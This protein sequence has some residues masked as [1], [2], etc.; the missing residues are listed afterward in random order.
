M[1]RKSENIQ[2]QGTEH[3]RR[4][5]LSEE[6]KRVIK[7]IYQTGEYSQ[8]QLAAMY[9]VSRRL[10]VFCIYPE[11]LEKNYQ[12]RVA[13]GGSKIYYDKQKHTKSMRECRQ[14]KEDLVK[15]GIVKLKDDGDN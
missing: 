3:D 5:K 13:N 10:I 2:I 6:D 12:N 4:R 7:E 14:H 9:G 15:A 1:P 11:R 8:R